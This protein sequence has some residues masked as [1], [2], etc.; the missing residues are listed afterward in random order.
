MT[1]VA[2]LIVTIDDAST[3]ASHD[4]AR[5][6]GADATVDGENVAV[7]CT[8]RV[9]DRAQLVVG[10]TNV[11]VDLKYWRRSEKCWHRSGEYRRRPLPV[12]DHSGSET[13]AFFSRGRPFRI[14]HISIS[15]NGGPCARVKLIDTIVRQER[16]ATS[17]RLRGR[18]GRSRVLPSA[19]T[20]RRRSHERGCS[21]D[22]C[23]WLHLS[24]RNSCL[25]CW[26]GQA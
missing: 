18:E 5:V 1:E 6:D 16:R 20:P 4:N 2:Q 3:A 12:E 21:S 8:N 19:R 9:V 24:D 22:T 14:T 26:I 23:R 25:R 11:G 7:D 10:L 13:A 17:T 15:E